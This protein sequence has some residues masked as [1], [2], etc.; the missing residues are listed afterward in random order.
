MNNQFR[1]VACHFHLPRLHKAFD[2]RAQR[3]VSIDFFLREIAQRMQAH[4]DGIKL[5]PERVLDIGCALGRDFPILQ[6]TYPNAQLFGLD[7]SRPMLVQAARQSWMTKLKQYLFHKRVHLVQA[8]WLMLPIA[9]D[10]IDLI[11]SNLALHWSASPERTLAQWAQVLRTNGLLLFSTF[12]PDTLKELRAAFKTINSHISVTDFFD[13]HDLGD[14]LLAQG[15]SDPVVDAE[16]LTITYE[17]P[18]SLLQD[19]RNLGIYPGDDFQTGLRGR[20]WRRQLYAALDAQRD[21]AGLIHLTVELIY[22]HAWKLAA[23]VGQMDREG[24][25]RLR[26]EDIGRRRQ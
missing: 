15:L 2:R 17:T 23:P 9:P 21:Q 19:V 1:A 26:P 24:V 4:L 14:M 12:G 8:D 25:V 13:M 11:W 16:R 5:T 7:W 3:L 18:Q 6:N 20:A 10:A 22:A